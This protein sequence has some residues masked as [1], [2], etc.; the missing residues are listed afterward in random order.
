M[1][2]RFLGRHLEIGSGNIGPCRTSVDRQRQGRKCINRR[3]IFVANLSAS[4]DIC[5]SGL[6]AAILGFECR[7][8]SDNIVLDSIGVLDPVN[9]I[10]TFRISTLSAA[11]ADILLLPVQRPPS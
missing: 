11:E 2:F 9:L 8:T 4:G 6:A 1:Y 3:W 10:E 7:S 5:T